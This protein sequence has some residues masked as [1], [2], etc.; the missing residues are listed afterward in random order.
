M[1]LSEDDQRNVGLTS[2]FHLTLKCSE[3]HAVNNGFLAVNFRRPGVILGYFD[4]DLETVEM[5][6]QEAGRKRSGQIRTD[7]SGRAIGKH[8]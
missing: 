2:L 7:D 3:R 4:V 5:A 8:T 1:I 6:S